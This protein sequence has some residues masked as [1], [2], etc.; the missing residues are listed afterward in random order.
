M[1]RHWRPLP[2]DVNSFLK[3]QHE[4]SP[5]VKLDFHVSVRQCL[6][7]SVSGEKLKEGSTPPSLDVRRD[8]ARSDEN[9]T[10]QS[11]AV[12]YEVLDLLKP[13]LH[14]TGCFQTVK[15]EITVGII[16]GPQWTSLD[17]FSRQFKKRWIFRFRI[18]QVKNTRV[19]KITR[20]GRRFYFS[21]RE[22]DEIQPLNKELFVLLK[23]F[24]CRV[25]LVP[26][27]FQT[28]SGSAELVVCSTA[29]LLMCLYVNNGPLS[30]CA[31]WLYIFNLQEVV[32]R[33]TAVDTRHQCL[34]WTN[35]TDTRHTKKTKNHLTSSL[36]FSLL[37]FFNRLYH[38]Y[39]TDI[40]F[41]LE[42]VFRQTEIYG[43]KKKKTVP[44]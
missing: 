15:S 32:V 3:T 21:H 11:V 19:Q 37:D 34:I 23:A 12:A 1:G 14:T 8:A 10:D 44:S 28:G 22:K 24:I 20:R 17:H 38:S 2:L 40:T 7:W 41:V 27:W 35:K 26:D 31:L 36:N 16:R 6:C 4:V 30:A 13:S 29:S 18:K 43:N 9:P 25:Q 39:R 42:K 5:G 33:S